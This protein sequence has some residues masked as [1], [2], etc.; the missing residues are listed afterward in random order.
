MTVC[1]GIVLFNPE[2]ERLKENI[3]TVLPQV[4]LL[5]LVDNASFD[6]EKLQETF[7]DE[8][9]VWIL[10]ETNTGVATALNQLIN[11]VSEKDCEWVLTLD[12]D[13][14]CGENLVEKLVAAGQ[15]N[16]KAAMI[17]PRII[18]RGADTEKTDPG[19][20]IQEVEEVPICITSGCLTNVK[21]VLDAGGFNDWL[22]I[23]HVDHD[24]CIRLRLKGYS[25]LRV[26]AAVLFQEYGL[27][28]VRRKLFFVPVEYHN[29]TPFRVYYQ[30]R[31]MLYMVRK[32]GSDFKP[33]PFFHYFRPIAV[34]FVK[35]MFEPERFQRLKAFIKGY[36]TGL[37]MKIN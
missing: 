9:I 18:E 32:Y 15:T 21:A 1:A 4:D 31:N 11:Y 34:F 5:V 14:V 24:M 13:S 2:S 28:V 19:K 12:Q 29:Y 27:E 35:F 37:F 3:N 16:E 8:R 20:P 22:F 33:L 17:S 7:V 36:V 30:A 26:N 25:I 23:D 10:N 6:T